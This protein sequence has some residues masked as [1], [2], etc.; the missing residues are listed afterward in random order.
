MLLSVVVPVYGSPQSL[1]HL[2]DRVAA[3]CRDLGMEHEL[4]LVDDR[5]PRGSWSVV[6]QL[7]E[8]DP[9]VVG[10]RLSRNFGQHAAIHAGLTRVRGDWVVV[11]DCDLQ[12][13]PEE[14][15][16]LLQHAWDGGFDV[17]RAR[18]VNRNDPWHRK[19]ASLAF[20]RVLSFL[21]DTHQSE[22]IGNF[23]VYHRRVI[24]ALSEWQEESKYFPAIIEWV[25]FAQSDM[26]VAHAA[27]HEGKSGYNLAK[28]I[29]LG[30]NVIVGFSDRPLKLMMLTGLSI[31]LL[32]LG[33]SAAL[34]ISR[35]VGLVSVEG[36]TS[37]V[38]SLWFIAGAII[39]GMGLT[40]LYVGRILIE[41]KG[42][43]TFVVDKVVVAA[44]AA[45]AAAGPELVLETAGGK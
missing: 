36:W 40:G 1:P 38:L 32:S 31:S 27:R 26:P 35:L 28:L 5:C 33:I 13:Q 11:M 41:A 44:Q 25:G 15:P 21:T 3:A 29:R 4:I 10:V 2:R 16:N 45:Q 18:R 34:V 7:A 23:G 8:T 9:N 19:L 37:V 24:D 20:Y 42:R 6:R 22:E 12:D 39:F 43:P 30:A 17:V 14:I